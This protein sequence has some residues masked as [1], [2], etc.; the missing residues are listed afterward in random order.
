MHPQAIFTPEELAAANIN[1]SSL[2]ATDYLNHFNEVVMLME[3]VPDMMDDVL[4]W[5]PRDYKTHFEH[6]VFADKA[7]A[8]AAYDAAPAETRAALEK[9]IEELDRKV[10][11]VQI[12][13]SGVET[14]QPLDPAV[15][16]RLML[17]IVDD[18]RPAI[19]RAS[20]LIN[21]VDMPDRLTSTVSEEPGMR[22][23]DAV[24]QLF[25]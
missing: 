16:D 10:V 15:M 25:D 11:D 17:T 1:P 14:S 4:A 2:L 5:E 6:S 22:A 19:D 3:M 18:I 20:A 12:M 24:D 21:A 9:V 8:I 13:L 7:L 23:Q